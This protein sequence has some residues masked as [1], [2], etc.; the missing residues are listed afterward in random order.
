[1]PS[2]DGFS[3]N[4]FKTHADFKKAAIALLRALKPNK[5][6]VGDWY[7]FRRCRSPAR[8]LCPATMGSRH[9]HALKHRLRRRVQRAHQTL[10]HRSSQ[11][12]RSKPCRILG[13]SRTARPTDGRDGNHFVRTTSSTRHHVP[14]ADRRREE[15][16]YGVA[17][18]HQW[19]GLSHHKLA[20][21]PR[22]D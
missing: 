6:P 12:N 5:T 16:H 8:R 14:F 15:K 7:S 4:S 18:D 11:R 13:P 9:A 17:G 19:K 10:R 2:L 1:M 20:L 22:H 3:N 21:V